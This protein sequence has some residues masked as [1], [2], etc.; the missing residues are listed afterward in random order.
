[1]VSILFI[2]NLV[3]ANIRKIDSLEISNVKYILSSLFFEKYLILEA[4]LFTK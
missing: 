2:S 4:N 3:F 1:M